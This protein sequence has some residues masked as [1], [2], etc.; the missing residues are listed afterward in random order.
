MSSPTRSIW[1]LAQICLAS[2]SHD[3]TEL[4]TAIGNP[5]GS[6]LKNMLEMLEIDFYDRGCREVGDPAATDFAD[7]EWQTRQPRGS[8]AEPPQ[9]SIS[10]NRATLPCAVCARLLVGLSKC[11]FWNLWKILVR[12]G[13]FFF[14][15][16]LFFEMKNF[17]AK[18]ID[19]FFS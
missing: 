9:P 5:S 11:D 3:I 6:H 10:R 13:Y 4:R 17:L 16:F 12:H 1:I 15:N 8:S 2:L 7:I 19:F 14:Q 18:K